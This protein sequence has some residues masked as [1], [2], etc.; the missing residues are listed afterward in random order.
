MS[1][2]KLR[3]WASP[4]VLLRYILMLDDTHHSVALGTAAGMF[5]GLT[6]TV[7]IQMMLVIAISFVT[8]PFFRFNRIAALITVYVSNPIT[9]VLIYY[10]LYRVGAIFVGGNV[11]RERFREILDFS[12]V[13][14]WKDAM[15]ALI[16]DVGTPLLIGTAIVPTVCALATYPLM[17][18]LLRW[19]R[20]TETGSGRTPTAG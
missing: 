18:W 1:Q 11:T 6:P 10:L 19:F 13:S 7:G 8:R 4:R 2:S 14:G 17:R 3:W 15:G 20:G 5:I 9:M 12:G 16:F